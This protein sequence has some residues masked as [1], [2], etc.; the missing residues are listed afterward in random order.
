MSKNIYVGN[1][2][3]DVSR[4]ELNELFG[5]FGQISSVNLISDKFTGRSKGFGFVEMASDQEADKAIQSLH[6]T[7]LKGRNITVNEARPRENS[8]GGGG[9]NGGGSRGGDDRRSAKR[10]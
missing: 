2:P 7:E 9:G 5:Q 1:L 4:E 10:W 8:F 6:E 3:Y